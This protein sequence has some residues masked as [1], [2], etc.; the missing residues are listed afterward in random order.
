MSKRNNSLVLLD[1]KHKLQILQQLRI[2]LVSLPTCCPTKQSKAKKFFDEGAVCSLY[3]RQ[4][5][6]QH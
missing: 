3:A 4:G 2:T 1:S 6:G 5:V